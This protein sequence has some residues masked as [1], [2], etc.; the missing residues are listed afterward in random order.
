[1]KEYSQPGVEE[2][3]DFDV[4]TITLYEK[5]E[6][7]GM[8]LGDTNMRRSGCMVISVLRNGLIETNPD[9]NFTFQEGDI[10]WMAGLKESL[11]WYSK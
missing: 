7:T 8:K 6:L 2:E 5:S 4:R 1:M 3:S 11:D 10:L 9:K